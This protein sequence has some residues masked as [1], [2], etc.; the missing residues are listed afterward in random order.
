MILLKAHIAFC[1]SICIERSQTFRDCSH[2]AL[3]NRCADMSYVTYTVEVLKITWSQ[4]PN[5]QVSVHFK[6]TQT[7]NPSMQFQLSQIGRF[8]YLQ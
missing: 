3:L 8:L 5:I 4:H 6:A 2:G 1:Q 7:N